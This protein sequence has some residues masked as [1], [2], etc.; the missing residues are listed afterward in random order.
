MK[1]IIS[2]LILLTGNLAFAEDCS[3]YLGRKG[4]FIRL[5]NIK[6][7][8]YIQWGDEEFVFCP[9]FWEGKSQCGG[10]LFESD[11]KGENLYVYDKSGNRW[12]LKLHMG[13]TNS[14][15]CLPNSEG[16][17]VSS[18]KKRKDISVEKAD[19]PVVWEIRTTSTY[20]AI[21]PNF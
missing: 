16:D 6:T 12:R 11:E 19:I 10:R 7:Q 15:V 9:D 13:S 20:R 2:I 4:R 1:F 17:F 8:H 3:S 18:T 21:F 14:S 5:D